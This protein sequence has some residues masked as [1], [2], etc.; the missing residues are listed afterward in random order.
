MEIIGYCTADSYKIK[1]LFESLQLTYKAQMIRDTLQ[2]TLA[3][4]QDIFIF[5]YGVVVTWGL[6]RGDGL[7]FIDKLAPFEREKVALVE[8][9]QFF[10]TLGEP[11]K[12]ID[13]ILTLAHLDTLTK[14]AVSHG[15]AQSVE[16]GYFETAVQRSFASTRKI[17]SDLAKYGK[18]ALSRKEIRK[19]MGEIFQERSS[20]NLHADVLDLP[21]FFWEHPELEPTYQMVANY[22]DIRPRVEVL[23]HRLDI[24]HE[25]YEVLAGELNHQ[26][27]SR[28]ETTIVLLIVVEVV[29]SLMR[30]VFHLI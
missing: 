22:L 9:D 21:E 10:A 14:M 26:H 18:I 16:L 19:K 17:P 24:M 2:V 12:I 13:D 28:L 3:E 27:S 15:I 23:N 1:P 20:I 8:T 4:D 7:R 11:Q 5:P 6:A 25:L 29:L 30:D